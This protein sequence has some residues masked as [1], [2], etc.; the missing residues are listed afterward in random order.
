MKNFI[1]ILMT[2]LFV[3][4]PSFAQRFNDS[5]CRLTYDGRRESTYERSMSSC[6][7]KVNEAAARFCQRFPNSNVSIAYRW[8]GQG[9]TSFFPCRG[10]GEPSGGPA[11]TIRYAGRTEITHEV[12]MGACQQRVNEA[13]DRYCRAHKGAFLRMDYSWNGR[14]APATFNCPR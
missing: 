5:L 1:L 9:E 6:Q 2:V 14:S 11:C 4:V 10:W 12:A 8:N 7:Q 13:A 3:A